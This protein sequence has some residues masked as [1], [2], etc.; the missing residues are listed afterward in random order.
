V[1]ESLACGIPLI[2]APWDDSEGLFGKNDFIVVPSG[3]AMQKAIYELLNDES[4]R[5]EL[6]ARG[7]STI[8]SA[9]TCAHRAQQLQDIATHLG[10]AN[11]SLEV[12]SA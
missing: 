7:L 10:V 12:P 4:M 11:V 1:F 8:L 9:H 2:C 3:R 6:S 5:S